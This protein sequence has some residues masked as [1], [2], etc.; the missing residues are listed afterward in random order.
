[1]RVFTFLPIVAA[2]SMA[3]DVVDGHHNCGPKAS[4]GGPSKV[5]PLKSIYGTT[6]QLELKSLTT[7]FKVL[8]NGDRQ[9]K[10][11]YGRALEHILNKYRNGASD[12]FL[13]GASD[14]SRAIE[15]TGGYVAG[16]YVSPEKAGQKAER[17]YCLVAYF[18]VGE[19]TH[20][21][22]QV[23]SVMTNGNSIRITYSKKQQ[24]VMG[25]LPYFIWL[26]LGE[27]DN[28]P[29]TLELFDSVAR[30]VIFMRQVTIPPG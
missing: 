22:W 29:Y 12:I 13:V 9:F 3:I 4:D 15:V 21:T 24:K 26:P 20:L 11:P 27:L 18:G 17:G 30:E 16:G 14:I 28:G 8:T 1:M 19:K 10:E 23:E 7:E 2:I 25:S 5:I 6:G